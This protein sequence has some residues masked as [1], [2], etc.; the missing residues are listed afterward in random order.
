MSAFWCE[1]LSD[2]LKELEPRADDELEEG[3]RK[4]A[5]EAQELIERM[6]DYLE[7]RLASFG[8]ERSMKTESLFREV[9]VDLED[10]LEHFYVRDMLSRIPKMVG[11]FLRLSHMVA[12]R[13]V[14]REVEIYL[15]EATRTYVYGFWHAS[16]AL[17]RAAVEHGLRQAVIK[18]TGQNQNTMREL[19]AAGLRWGLLDK[20]SAD[21][22]DTV[23]TCGNRVLHREPAN[24]EGAWEALCAARGV[25]T[26]LFRSS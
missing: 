14:P 5:Q 23:I 12:G 3:E 18:Q 11:R 6:T 15:K 7:G 20:P 17:S 13:P 1:Y 16:V 26:R 24:A 10:Q 22:T 25:L 4:E 19:V 8:D 9:G 21:L 2:K